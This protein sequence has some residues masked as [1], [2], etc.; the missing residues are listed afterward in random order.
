MKPV[1]LLAGQDFWSG[2]AKSM[3][4]QS[5]EILEHLARAKGYILRGDP[6]RALASFLVGLKHSTENRLLG[7]EKFE[8][9]SALREALQLLLRDDT[10]RR[11]APDGLSYQPGQEKHLL[12]AAA[13]ALKA[14]Q[15]HLKKGD[16]EQNR[17]RKLKMDQALTRGQKM[18]AERRP[19]EAD[20]AF[21]EALSLYVDE[22]ALFQMVGAK[23]MAADMPRQALPYLKQGLA[24]N[25]GNQPCLELLSKA[26]EQLAEH[27]QALQYHRELLEVYGENPDRLL[28]LAELQL[29]ARD[30]GAARASAQRALERDPTLVKA[31]RLLDKLAKTHKG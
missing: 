8:F 25:P 30:P 15:A 1:R 18:L 16:V 22:I 5:K 17:A 26:Y 7:R 19:D 13:Q 20:A 24:L 14:L 23:Y 3:S 21:Q 10:V 11:F 4:A 9:E 28:R 31:R 12:L 6:S 27:E 29:G 2:A